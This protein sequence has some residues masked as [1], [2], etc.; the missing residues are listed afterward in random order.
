ML[1]L[2]KKGITYKGDA[3]FRIIINQNGTVVVN[4]K[5]GLVSYNYLNLESFEKALECGECFAYKIHDFNG[6]VTIR[7]VK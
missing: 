5:H 2:S 6:M 7:G 3:G 1:Y 4:K